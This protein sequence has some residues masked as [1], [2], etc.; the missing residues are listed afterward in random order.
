[1]CNEA[2]KRG[3]KPLMIFCWSPSSC[4]WSKKE[5]MLFPTISSPAGL[6]MGILR[7]SYC[8]YNPG[9][10]GLHINMAHNLKNTT[11]KLPCIVRYTCTSVLHCACL[12]PYP[13]PL[14]RRHETEPTRALVRW[15]DEPKYKHINEFG[16]VPMLENQT[17][18]VPRH[19]RMGSL[20]TRN[21]TWEQAD[22]K[23]PHH[24]FSQNVR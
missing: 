13:T 3:Q 6:L 14:L 10:S 9:R 17:R 2:Q 24:N 15:Y 8:L 19:W 23:F 11:T 22:G 7:N 1:M 18:G 4:P 21:N 5:I 16:L 20:T 12:H